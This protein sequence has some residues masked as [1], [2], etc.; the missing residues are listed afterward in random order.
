MPGA[1]GGD[2]VKVLYVI[3]DN[4]E[5]G[6]TPAIMSIF[7][8]RLIGLQGLFLIGLFTAILNIDQFINHPSLLIIVASLA[9]VSI[10]IL[11]FFIAALYNYKDN[12]DPFR[13]ILR[14]E[15]PGFSA[16]RKIYENLR[17]YRDH[18]LL[19]FKCLGISII[20]QCLGL[21]VFLFI[22]TAIINPDPSKYLTIASIFPAGMFTIALPIAPGGLGVGHVA[23]DRLFDLIGLQQGA[24][25]FNVFLLSQMAL[26]LIGSIPY[27]SLKKNESEADFIGAK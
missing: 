19:I 25:I 6:K 15:I 27:L 12:R 1:V 18:K 16:L 4:K 20:L 7:L 2:L 10:A 26:N 23:F 8:D 13:R 14:S 11:L 22:T 17:T 5:K 3:R 24:S 21:L 9:G